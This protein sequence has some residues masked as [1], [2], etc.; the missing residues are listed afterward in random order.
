MNPKAFEGHL[1]LSE[2]AY[3]AIKEYI[4][5]VDLRKQPPNSKLDEKQLVAQL[6]VSRTPVRE[7]INRLAA[8]GFLEVVPYKGVFIARKTEQEI[9]EILMVRATLEGMAARLATP[10]FR[11]KDFARMREM[12]TLFLNATLENQRYEFSQANIKFHEFILK[13]S[14]CGK[15]IDIAKSLYDHM[16]LIRFRTSGFLPRLESALAQHLEL[17]DLFEARDSEKAERLMRAH[18]EESAQYI[19]LWEQ[20]Y[21]DSAKEGEIQ[22]KSQIL[23][24]KFGHNKDTVPPPDID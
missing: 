7:A 5:T 3:E 2:K 4:L 16:R 21:S 17:I 10:N 15:L 23:H 19:G 13:R 6:K 11:P 8:E 20:L 1:R 9:L 18:I 12:F 14:E 22:K 24:G